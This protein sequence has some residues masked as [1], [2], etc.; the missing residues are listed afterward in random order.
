MPKLPSAARVNLFHG[1]L[2][3]WVMNMGIKTGKILDVF[4]VLG[5]KKL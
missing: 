3:C 1:K 5:G 2:V 4:V